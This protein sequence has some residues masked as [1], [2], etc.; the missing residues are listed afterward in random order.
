[1]NFF[2][3]QTQAQKKTIYLY[4]LMAIAVVCLISITCMSLACWVNF[5]NPQ[6]VPAWRFWE[7][8]PPKLLTVVV[9]GILFIIVSASGFEYLKLRSGGA[10]VAQ[11]LGGQLIPQ[12]TT[13][14]AEKRILNIVEEMALASGVPVP[15]VY[16]LNDESIN[17]FAA[18]H[19]I[20]NAVIGVTRGC[21]TKLSRDEQQGV[22]AHEFSHIF[23]GDMKI[24]M[25]LSALLFGILFIA[26]IGEFMLRSSRVRSSNGRSNPLPFIGLALF[27]LGYCGVFF[28]NLI[29]A[30]VSRQREFLADASAIQY[31]RN[32]SGIAGALHKISLNGSTLS[33]P[34]AAQFSHMYF[35]VGVSKLTSLFATHP[36]LKDRISRIDPKGETKIK[37]ETSP[38]TQAPNIHSGINAASAAAANAPTAK[39]IPFAGVSLASSVIGAEDI[40]PITAQ[41]AED[42]VNT[43]GLTTP[44]HLQ[45]ARHLIA[46]LP[47]ELTHALHEPYQVRGIILG[48]FLDKQDLHA[49]QQWDSLPESLFNGER[50]QLTQL[51]LG[52]NSLQAPYRLPILEM[53][54]PTLKQLPQDLI[55]ELLLAIDIFI[56][57]DE[58]LTIDEW[59][60]S[61]ILHAQTQEQNADSKAAPDLNDI[62]LLLSVIVQQGHKELAAAQAAFT[63]ATQGLSLNLIERDQITIRSIENSLTALANLPSMKKLALLKRLSI[64]V[65]H[66]NKI[67]YREAELLRAIAARLA[68]PMPPLLIGS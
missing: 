32:P 67:T 42:V 52:V 17:A 47:D 9:L 35:S 53:A 21:I 2:E 28:A 1:M 55:D 15:P 37:F 41:A 30:A 16:V 36:P 23:H 4:L 19:S 27:I 14:F 54:I 56:R 34:N 25:R 62:G 13:N 60:L 51:A 5:G 7:A 3:H 63:A 46:S 33:H 64:A 61:S 39:I 50:D 6:S 18:G 24:N 48:L 12:N 29:K 8:I 40:T 26:L 43:V 22:I 65:M 58:R 57:S 59:C 11:A 68:C 10:A 49:Q 44:E 38:S 20:D 66:D 45:Y 31:T